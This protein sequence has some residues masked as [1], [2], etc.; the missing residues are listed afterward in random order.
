MRRGVFQNLAIVSGKEALIRRFAQSAAG[1]AKSLS[2]PEMIA[3]YIAETVFQSVRAVARL[4][5]SAMVVSAAKDKGMIE[6]E[7]QISEGEKSEF[8]IK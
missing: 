2:N 3:R 1:I 5:E 8:K 6:E 7:S 4:E